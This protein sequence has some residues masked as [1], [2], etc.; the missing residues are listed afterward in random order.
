MKCYRGDLR[1][2]GNILVPLGIRATQSITHSKGGTSIL[3][4]ERCYVLPL[5]VLHFT[6]MVGMPFQFLLLA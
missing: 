6:P 5:L 3:Q 4:T 2:K 1:T